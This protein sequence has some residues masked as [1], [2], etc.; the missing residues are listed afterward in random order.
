MTVQEASQVIDQMDV[1]AQVVAESSRSGGRGRS[2]RPGSRRC[3]VCGKAGHNAR[4]CQ[5]VIKPSREE[6]N[7]WSA[8]LSGRHAYQPRYR[9]FQVKS[10]PK[11]PLELFQIFIP[12]S[13]LDVRDEGDLPKTFKA[14]EP[15]FDHIQKAS[16]ELFIPGTSLTIDEYMVP[17]KGRFK[18]T[19]VIKNKP[20]PVGYYRRATFAEDAGQE[21]EII[22]NWKPYTTLKDWKEC[23]YNA[24]FNRYAGESQARKR[25]RTGMEEDIEDDEARQKHLQRDINHVF[26]DINSACLACK[27]F[28]QGQPRPFKKGRQKEAIYSR[29]QEM[30]QLREPDTTVKYAKWQFVTMRSAGTSTTRKFRVEMRH[31]SGGWDDS[32]LLACHFNNR[33]NAGMLKCYPQLDQTVK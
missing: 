20:A 17:F 4:T 21:V 1:N 2:E 29:Y 19:I 14:A 24:I 8:Y 32:R 5:V 10:L 33:A 11:E 25:N 3:G 23:I 26:R 16:A 9:D 18:E 22:Y 28:R 12:I 13:H 31:V 27:G 6:Y 15:W 30:H 7:F